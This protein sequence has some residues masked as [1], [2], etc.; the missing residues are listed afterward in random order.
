MEETD[1]SQDQSD[2]VVCGSHNQQIIH[3]FSCFAEVSGKAGLFLIS[4][5][6]K[7]HEVSILNAF[8]FTILIKL[9]FE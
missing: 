8:L 6:A 2:S 1:V 3:L 5:Y 9:N 7:L 4:F